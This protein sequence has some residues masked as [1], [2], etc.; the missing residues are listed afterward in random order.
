MG[1]GSN[2]GG[3][4]G[5]TLRYVQ[6]IAQRGRAGFVWWGRGQLMCRYGECATRQVRQ[7]WLG[8]VA[9]ALGLAAAAAEAPSSVT[10]LQVTSWW[11]RR[12]RRKL[13]QQLE[14]L[15]RFLLLQVT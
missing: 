14:P 5:S 13:Q 6:R 4:A 2:G 11:L 12:F 7:G 10:E 8:D 15:A 3:E 1:R 9:R